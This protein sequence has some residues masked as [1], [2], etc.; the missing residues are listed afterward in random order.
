MQVRVHALRLSECARAD[1]DDRRER[2]HVPARGS[3]RGRDRAW[4]GSGG[5]ET[6]ECTLGRRGV[7]RPA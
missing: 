7:A 6:V 3:S 5:W 4:C 2:S 1:V